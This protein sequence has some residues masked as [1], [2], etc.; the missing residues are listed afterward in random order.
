[1]WFGF[2]LVD[3]GLVSPDALCNAMRRQMRFRRPIG[4]LA[5][6]AGYM[7]MRD[8]YEVLALQH[9]TGR[10]FGKLAI[11]LGF[12]SR[13]D[14]GLMMLQQNA[15]VPD[16][17]E[18]LVATGGIE[19]DVLRLWLEAYRMRISCPPEDFTEIIAHQDLNGLTP[20][21]SLN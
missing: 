4:Q 10:P 12:L 6:D 8:V 19:A 16:L 21:T 7:T 3:E 13:E 20:S 17:E 5:I 18:S 2:D 15:E 11:E 9:E 1:M 14:L